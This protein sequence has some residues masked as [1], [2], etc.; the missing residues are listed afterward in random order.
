[1]SNTNLYRFAGWSAIL[2][3]LTS[4]GMFALIG[5]GRGGAFMVVSIIAALFTLAA[6]YGV[7]VFHRPQAPALSLAMLVFAIVGLT[8]ENLGMGPDTPMGMV[9]S[10]IYGT[11]FLL[12]GYLGYGNAQMPRWL[13]VCAYV[14]GFASLATAVASALG[15]VGA[16]STVP[17]VLFVAWIAWSVGIWRFFTSSKSVVAAV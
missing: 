12:V 6:L 17:M 14:V 7:Y 15:Q 9:T 13:A 1:M 8:L 10:V 2:S 4:F 5:D 11:T 3:I 16:A